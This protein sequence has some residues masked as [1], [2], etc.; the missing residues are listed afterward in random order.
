MCYISCFLKLQKSSSDLRLVTPIVLSLSLY[1]YINF[2]W[3]R[4]VWR[5]GL[6][7]GEGFKL[8]DFIIYFLF[9]DQNNGY[10][11]GKHIW[12][13]NAHPLPN[14]KLD[15]TGNSLIPKRYS[16]KEMSFCKRVMVV[17]VVIVVMVVMV[18]MVVS[19]MKLT[20]FAGLLVIW[21]S[22]L[23]CLFA[24]FSIILKHEEHNVWN[25][26]HKKKWVL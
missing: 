22:F 8:T 25:E 23:S 15:D 13:L 9:E 6:P 19:W 26:T 5:Y 1:C 21:Q 24:F 14:M 3:R 4:K 11:F 17:M 7:T 18:V 12:S 20:I 16:K 2:F 10:K